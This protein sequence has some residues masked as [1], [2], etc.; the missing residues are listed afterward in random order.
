MI[1]GGLDGG[2]WA[3]YIPQGPLTPEGR[4]A[5]R[6][7]ALRRLAHIHAMVDRHPESFGVALTAD[8]APRIA[9]AGRRVVYLSMENGYPLGEDCHCRRLYSRRPAWRVRCIS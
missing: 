1:E 7:A 3:T 5:A 6:D 2:F 8:D 4:A 9:A